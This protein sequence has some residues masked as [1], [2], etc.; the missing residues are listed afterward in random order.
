MEYIIEYKAKIENKQTRKSPVKWI[1]KKLVGIK[2]EVDEKSA[3]W[4]KSKNIQDFVKNQERKILKNDI[5][6]GSRK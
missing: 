5:R 2:E 3:N 4:H 6:E 1:K